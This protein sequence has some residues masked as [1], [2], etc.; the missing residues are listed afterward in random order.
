MATSAISPSSSCNIQLVRQIKC[1]RD[2]SGFVCTR[3]MPIKCKM[4]AYHIYE[5]IDTYQCP[6][7]RSHSAKKKK[8]KIR[9]NLITCSNAYITNHRLNCAT[10]I[11]QYG[12]VLA[13][14]V[15]TIFDWN[16]FN[17][18]IFDLG[19]NL[20]I[21]NAIPTALSLHF[22]ISELNSSEIFKA[23]NRQPHV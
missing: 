11:N 22:R 12:H 3:A 13:P 15:Q 9:S 5:S 23:N 17:E 2:R 20:T 1:E 8:K 18:N 14:K 19:M 16:D 10:I 21:R 6:L 7:S 4:S